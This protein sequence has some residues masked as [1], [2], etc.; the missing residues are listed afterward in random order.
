MICKLRNTWQRTLLSGSCNLFRRYSGR[1]CSGP[2]LF[3]F[4]MFLPEFLSLYLFNCEYFLDVLM[5]GGG[6]DRRLV[7]TMVYGAW[8][9]FYKYT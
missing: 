1:K 4:G 5:N 8:T 2:K 3:P 6:Y 9:P 7:W